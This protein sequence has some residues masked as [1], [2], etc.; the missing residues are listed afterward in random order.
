MVA[1]LNI[2]NSTIQ[3]SDT[4]TFPA[5][6]LAHHDSLIFY[7]NPHLK[8]MLTAGDFRIVKTRKQDKKP[9]ALRYALLKTGVLVYAIPNPDNKGQTSGFVGA[10]IKESITGLMR[11]LPHYGKYSWL[12]FEGSRPDNVMK[13]TFPPLHSPLHYNIPV[14]GQQPVIRAR[15]QPES[16]L[17]TL[18]R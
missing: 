13:G 2:K 15:L 18:P 1:T 14:K 10:N 7:L 4:I 17:T 5:A 12:G 8:V 16:P 3:L 9:D 6:F 11:L